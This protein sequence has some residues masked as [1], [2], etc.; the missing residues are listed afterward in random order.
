ML[1]SILYS[2]CG[3]ARNSSLTTL[4]SFIEKEYETGD[5]IFPWHV[6]IFRRFGDTISYKYVC[7]GTLINPDNKGYIVLTAAV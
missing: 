7:G 1:L 6:A 2:E 3:Q 5:E 4:S